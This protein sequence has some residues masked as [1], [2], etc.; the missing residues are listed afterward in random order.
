MLNGLLA[1]AI[2][3]ECVLT[4]S[5]SCFAC[6]CGTPGPACAYVSAT[7]V[8]FV[9]TPVFTDDDGSGTFVQRT[10]YKFTV[11]EIFKGL[12]EGTKEVWVDPGSYTSCYAEYKLGVKLLVFASE[13]RIFPTDTA[14][15]TATKP[16]SKNKPLPPGFDSKM[17]VY[18]APE[19]SGTREADAASAE[20]AWLQ[21]W[22]R[23]ESRAR[24]QGVVL[25]SFKWPLAGVKVVAKGESGRLATITDA[26]GA[27]SF[28]PVKPGK[29]DL[30]PN[31]P[32]YRLSRKS[33]IAVEEHACGYARLYMGTP[34]LLSG[35]VTDKSGRPV[36]GEDLDLVQIRGSEETSLPIGHETA[37]APGS[38]RY[39]NLP[40]GDYLIGVNLDS[41][42][43][44][45]SPYA[46]TYAP[47]VSDRAQAKVFH[48]GPAQKISG[49]RFQ[50]PL[51]LPLRTVHVQ[52]KWPDGQS[53]GPKVSVVTNETKDDVTDLEETKED[54]SVLVQC[55]VARECRIEAKRWL[56]WPDHGAKPEVAASLA[57]LIDAG[58][59]PVSI[60]LTLSERRAQWMER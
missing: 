59:A 5:V 12:P 42:P 47:G 2:A 6:E 13:G 24:I 26:A 46:R 35:T 10:L 54:G 3:F 9:G 55:F 7:P 4:L 15:M 40:A 22:K 41:A 60:T 49:I 23:G 25:D 20:I 19:C 16:T 44:V 27:F 50:L 39:E 33:M 58:D 51:P 37:S 36:V 17:P 45:D 31:L 52:V 53:A 1:R 57:T 48:L 43:G 28:E 21:S 8:G 34:G 56:T 29:Y 30:M 11:D 38:F 14:A 32:K 18:F